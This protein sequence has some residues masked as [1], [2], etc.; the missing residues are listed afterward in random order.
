M[1]SQEQTPENLRE[2]LWLKTTPFGHPIC[3]AGK[4][5]KSRGYVDTISE[6]FGHPSQ[7]V[8]TTSFCST[9]KV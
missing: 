2:R 5:E 7:S 3:C 8:I 4:C 1:A 9:D 6:V